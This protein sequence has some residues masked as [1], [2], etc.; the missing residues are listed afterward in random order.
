MNVW[1]S[2]D[3]HFGHSNILK[4]IN[5]EGDQV[6]P[7]FDSIKDMD[8]TIIERHNEFV[9]PTD[10]WYCLGDISFDI[11]SFHRIMPRLNGHKR[12]ILGNHDKFP[13]KEYLKYFEKIMESWQPQR[14]ILFTHRPVLVNTD[15]V[16]LNVHGHVHRMRKEISDNHMNISLEMTN[17]YPIHWDQIVENVKNG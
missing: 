12:L 14:E 3:H 11:E 7:G 5:Y 10:K 16:K 4:F 13:M 15:R 6:R 17:Y 9:K 1:F 8:E 2:S